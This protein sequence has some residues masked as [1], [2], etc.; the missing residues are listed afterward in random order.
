VRHLDDDEFLN[1]RL[2]PLEDLM[3]AVMDGK[4]TDGKTQT[5]VLKAYY[6]LQNEEK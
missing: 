4:I 2:M 5:A 3:Q 6:W 1:V